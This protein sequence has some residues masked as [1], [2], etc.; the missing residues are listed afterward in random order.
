MVVELKKQR[1]TIEK[2]NKIT[3]FVKQKF[4]EKA[5]KQLIN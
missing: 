3:I 5:E 2:T 1:K 4:F